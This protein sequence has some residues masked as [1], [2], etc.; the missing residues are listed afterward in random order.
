MSKLE[1]QKTGKL[2]AAAPSFHVYAD[3]EG[4]AVGVAEAVNKTVVL[5]MDGRKSSLS[6]DYY[7]LIMGYDP[8]EKDY[9]LVDKSRA[10]CEYIRDKVK[11]EFAGWSAEKIEKIKKLPAIISQEWDRTDEQQAVFAFIKDVKIQENGI[12]V[13]FQKYFPIPFS[14]LR[15]NLDEL[16]INRFEIYRTH[17]TIKNVD[18]VEVMQE[19]GYFPVV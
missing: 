6:S 14:F 1:I 3:G 4:T 18:L 16:A 9:V 17:W 13:Y 5:M 12:K 7:N 15:E 11:E 19:A 2:P 10:L 8:F